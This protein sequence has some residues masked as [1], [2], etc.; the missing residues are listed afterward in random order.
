MT[1]FWIAFLSAFCGV[2]LGAF[3]IFVATALILGGKE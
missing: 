1:T 3:F 2:I